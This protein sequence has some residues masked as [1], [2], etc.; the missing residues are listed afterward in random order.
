M[1][2]TIRHAALLLGVPL[3]SPDLTE[4]VT[5]HSLRATGAQ[6]FASAGLDEWSIQLLG[7]WG[8]KAIR[9]YTREAALERSSSWAKA[10]AS[11]LGPTTLGAAPLDMKQIRALLVPL[12]SEA[13]QSLFP[14]FLSSHAE[15]LKQDIMAELKAQ[16]RQLEE[17]NQPG[18]VLEASAILRDDSPPTYVKNKV[19]GIVHV[20]SSSSS[21]ELSSRATVCGWRYASRS[22]GVLLPDAGVCV[23]K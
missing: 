22:S 7:R 3:V 23:Y 16:Q 12:V 10:V 13:A 21:P 2:D 19:T 18:Q 14:S 8:S 15:S 6:G 9:G 4:H 11:T 17:K 5:G 20:L 1:T